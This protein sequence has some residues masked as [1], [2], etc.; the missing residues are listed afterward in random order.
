MF[1]VEKNNKLK[2]NSKNLAKN[3]LMTVLL[4]VLASCAYQ[5]YEPTQI[6]TNQAILILLITLTVMLKS[7]K[8][9]TA[10]VEELFHV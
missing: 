8:F 1:L 5:E 9:K 10:L 7:G 2:V 4:S 3:I 6:E